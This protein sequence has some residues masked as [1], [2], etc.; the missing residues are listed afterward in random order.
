M[1]IAKLRDNYHRNLCKK[2]LF[3]RKGIPNF[4]D[5]SSKT[6]VA[7]ALKIIARLNYPL[8]KQAPPGQTA[9]VLFE[10]ITKDFLRDS[11][12][13]LNHLRPG[14]WLFA[15]NQNI[16]RFEQYEH[17][18]SLRRMLQEKA[19]I[20][21]SLGRRLSGHPRHYSWKVSNFRRRD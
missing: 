15:I 7:V 1:A 8:A 21:R 4:A 5:G 10:Q 3:I 9:G 14:K 16:S 6:S 19:G 18:A 11:F 12:K 17:V 20:R 2:I 13:L